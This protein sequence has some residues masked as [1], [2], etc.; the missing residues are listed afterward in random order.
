[1]V[2]DSYV[3]IEGIYCDVI[4]CLRSINILS[5]FLLIST[6]KNRG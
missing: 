4:S 5:P 1:M 2:S 6:N 3:Y